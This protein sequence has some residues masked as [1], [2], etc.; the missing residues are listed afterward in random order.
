ML[1]GV[2]AITVTE[3]EGRHYALTVAYGD[4][5]G[6]QVIDV[7]TPA[8][9]VAA[10][11]AAQ[12]EG[13]ITGLELPTDVTTAEIR[14]RHYALVA[15]LDTDSIQII[16]ITNPYSLS[17]AAVFD[18]SLA[19]PNNVGVMQSGGH[20]Y[21]LVLGIDHAGI[22]AYLRVINITDPSNPSHV[23]KVDTDTDSFG[24]FDLGVSVTAMQVGD[25][26]Y[27]LMAHYGGDGL[28]VVDLTDP[29]NPS[30]PFL[31]HL[32]LDL[33]GDGDGYAT[34]VGQ[35]DDGLSLLFR[36]VTGPDDHTMDLSYDG[37][38]ALQMGR[39]VLL[40]ADG[41]LLPQ[42]VLPEPGMPNSLSDSK[43]ISI[44]GTDP[45]E[46]FVT[47]WEVPSAGDSITLP[48]AQAS[49]TYTVYWGD[50]HAEY[51]IS[52]DATHKYEEAGTYTVSTWNLDRIRLG[53]DAAGAAML[54]SIESW[55]TAR[56]TSMSDA[57]SGTSSMMHAAGDV[58][59]LS[60]VRSMAQ[61]F[62]DS[63]V[64]DGLSGWSVSS[65]EEMSSVF[66]G[67][68]VFDGNISGWD[69]SSAR[70]ISSMFRGASSFNQDISGWNIS[71]VEDTSYMFQDALLFNQ[72]VSGWDVSSVKDMTSMFDGASLFV[73]NLGR[74][75]VTV[76]DTSINGTEVPGIVGSI[77]AQN[78]F[79][80]AQN[81]VYGIGAG[82]DSAH[83]VVLEDGLA[84]I[85]VDGARKQYVANITASGPTVFGDGNNWKT[86]DVTVQGEV[87]STRLSVDAGS[88]QNVIEGVT[89]TLSG[90]V[91]G[92]SPDT[93]MY[94]WSQTSPTNPAAADIS[95]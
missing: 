35:A 28:T 46:H 37:V 6:L 38:G 85:S 92:A 59:D 44:Y 25:R 49:G 3:I 22:E 83:F 31:P 9:P 18:E 81:P 54:R 8:D 65:V 47:T 84:M 13:G 2:A 68:A 91:T 63:Y 45:R 1:D 10:G 34:Y 95:W 62:R 32:Q 19:G 94:M 93:P 79:L 42:V 76:E 16:D 67:A 43:Q 39:T 11:F 87:P 71:S 55:G 78:T 5:H 57:F 23:A 77:M 64:M 69:V 86:V 58:P 53:A 30:N 17:A 74:W 14:G 56:W 21:A 70:D 90:S 33:G 52:G 40:D 24:R 72:D 48:A 60:E 27:A 89:V 73:Q 80:D 50:G 36:Y 75:Y 29:S 41:T 4:I 82:A 51:G 7:T 12:G 20:H 15:A 66:R 88:P 26:H 61:M